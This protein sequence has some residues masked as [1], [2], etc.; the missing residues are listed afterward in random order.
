MRIFF[1][2]ISIMMFFSSVFADDYFS[3]YFDKVDTS[4]LYLKEATNANP[5][6]LIVLTAG[7]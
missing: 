4:A 1:S 6:L 5:K 3:T 2:L 7:V